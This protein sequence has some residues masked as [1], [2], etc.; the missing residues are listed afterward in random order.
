MK[1]LSEETEIVDSPDAVDLQDAKG[2]I[3][4]DRVNFSYDGKVTALKDI[5]VNIAPGTSVA[6]VG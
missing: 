6:L 2:A 3:E 5:S 4:L 1:L